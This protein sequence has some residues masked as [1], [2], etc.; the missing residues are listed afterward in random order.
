M[1]GTKT[2]AGGRTAE[3]IDPNAWRARKAVG[4]P[5]AKGK[6]ADT[7]PIATHAD[8]AVDPWAFDWDACS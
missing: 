7:E 1:D 5:L 2:D 8:D 3:I 4:R 6:P